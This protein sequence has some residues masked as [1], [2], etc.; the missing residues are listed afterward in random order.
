YYRLG[1]YEKAKK[2]FSALTDAAKF[3]Q[4]AYYNLGLTANK[5]KD[6]AAAIAW[7]QRAFR[8]GKSDKVKI[9]AREALKR[10]GAAPISSSVA[11]NK[12]TGLLSA[13]LL[14][15]SNVTLV[16]DDQATVTSKSDTSLVLSAFGAKWLKGGRNDGVR[17][18]LKGYLQNYNTQTTYNYT[19]LGLGAAKY[20][21]LGSWKM[22]YGGFWDETYLGGSQYQRVL[23]ADVKARKAL[24]K[25][26]QL[27]LRYKA[28]QII[29]TESVTATNSGNKHL[30]GWRQQIRL[31]NQTHSGKNRYR[32]YYQLELNDRKDDDTPA[33]AAYLF[34]SYSPTRHTIRV[35]GWWDLGGQWALRLDGRY[36]T[37][38]YNDDYVLVGNVMESRDDTQT[39]L[40]ARLSKKLN[41]SLQLEVAYTAMNNDSSVDAE[42]YDRTLASVGLSS[43]F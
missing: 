7:F 27:R 15:D 12:W 10:L 5:Q 6:K 35:T 14:S 38:S 22:R 40:S 13:S 31:G 29:A 41:K 18:F 32:V 4:L 16:N 20:D 8:T 23:S 25:N 24:S 1:L 34:R 39:R 9:L 43:K 30:G 26:N 3:K 42:S 37:S 36:R 2:S 21:Q 19:Q 28:S 11:S 33:D 17:P